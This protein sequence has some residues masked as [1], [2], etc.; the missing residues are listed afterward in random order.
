MTTTQTTKLASTVREILSNIGTTP[1]ELAVNEPVEID[2]GAFNSLT[3]EKVWEDAIKVG[4]CIQQRGDLVSDPAVTLKISDDGELIVVEY[5]SHTGLQPQYEYD[6]DGIE[7]EGI[8]DFL[9]T[10]SDNLHAQGHV[11]R[12]NH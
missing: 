3:I 7:N 8:N 6:P 9:D 10:W 4:H 11:E 12:A 2:G 1:S 5:E